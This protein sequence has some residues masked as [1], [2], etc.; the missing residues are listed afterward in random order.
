ML[1]KVYLRLLIREILR[2]S[3]HEIIIKSEYMYKCT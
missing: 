1:Q 2:I 3:I